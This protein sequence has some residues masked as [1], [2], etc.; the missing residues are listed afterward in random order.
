MLNI[1]TDHCA[2]FPGHA[3]IVF[4]QVKHGQRHGEGK[5]GKL[6]QVSE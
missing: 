1:D 2:G 5:V 4:A 6:R 3:V